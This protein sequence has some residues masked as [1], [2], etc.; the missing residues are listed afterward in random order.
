MG[1]PLGLRTSVGGVGFASSVAQA[2]HVDDGDRTSGCRLDEPQRQRNAW[3]VV[4]GPLVVLGESPV[5]VRRLSSDDR[6]AVGDERAQPERLLVAATV[7]AGDRPAVAGDE[8]RLVV[9]Q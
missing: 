9:G 5:H 3:T 7:V 2:V 1:D 4:A 8:Q 6:Q